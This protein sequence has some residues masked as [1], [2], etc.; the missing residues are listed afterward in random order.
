MNAKQ[1]QQQQQQVLTTLP[2][3]VL[4]LLAS[5]RVGTS[6]TTAPPPPPRASRRSTA[7]VVFLSVGERRRDSDF[8]RFPTQDEAVEL[9]IREWPQ[10]LKT[11]TWE[12]PVP[13]GQQVVRYVLEGSGSVQIESYNDDDEEGTECSSSSVTTAR[14]GPGTLVEVPGQSLL[15]W[16][17]GSDEAIILTPSYE[18][19]GKLL[20]TAA[21]LVVLCGALIA[22]L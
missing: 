16:D 7:A 14:V 12:E 4:L 6:F 11:G 2:T 18:E 9:G 5:C 22:S 1:H 21:I 19:G 13:L 15:S 20:A 3:L 8:I 10:Q 17:F